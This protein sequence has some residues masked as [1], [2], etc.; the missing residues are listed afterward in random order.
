MTYAAESG[1]W[2]AK[3]G[4]PAYEV[5]G[6]NGQMRA[7][8]LRDARKLTLY[9]SVTT[10][11]RCAAAPGLERWKAEQVLLAALTLPRREDEAEK[12]WLDRVWRDAGEQGKKAAERGT[13]IHAAIEQ[14]LLG[15]E[16]DKS[17]Q[18]HVSG[19]LF[20]LDQV[21]GSQQWKPEKSFTDAFLGYGGKVDL[22]SD[23]WVIDFKSKEF[24][25]EDEMDTYDTHWMQL[26]A[27]ANGLQRPEARCGI[28]YVSAS[29]PGVAKLV[30]LTEEQIEKGWGMFHSL[31][32]YWQAKTGYKP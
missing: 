12:E 10:I 29:V 27:Y 14:R 15:R 6:K 21:C 24:S 8:T 16:F 25:A 13:E 17:Y 19:A 28:V 11:I 9:P 4:S 30:E 26:A 20:A 1:H 2:Y 23:E 5:Q 3:D 22:H 31:L 32:Q 18:P 7:T